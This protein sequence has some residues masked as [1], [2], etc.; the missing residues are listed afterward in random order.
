M[1]ILHHP[2]LS[3]FSYITWAMLSY[4]ARRYDSA[5]C[6]SKMS[7]DAFLRKRFMKQIKRSKSSLQR[8][9]SVHVYKMVDGA[10]GKL[11]M[12]VLFCY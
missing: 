2:Y 8:R 4:S 6:C 5:I 1:A 7:R 9:G 12:H 11:Q 10:D 3:P